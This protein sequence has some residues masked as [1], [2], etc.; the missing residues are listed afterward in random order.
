MVAIVKKDKPD[1]T[2]CS[3]TL[4]SKKFI[5]TAAHCFKHLPKDAFE[6][7]LG[8]DNLDTR[9]TNWQQYQERRDIFKL[10]IHPGYERQ[11]HNDIAI[12]ELQNEVTFNDGIYPICLPE[13][14]SP[15]SRSGHSVIVAGYGS[16]GASENKKLRSAPLQ[17][18]TQKACEDK[19]DHLNGTVDLF[20]SN[21]MCAASYVRRKCITNQQL[22]V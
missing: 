4:V 6:V 11:Y 20:T 21:T 8:T 18:L 9:P 16:T 7:V 22:F 19:Y 15:F 14:A 1:T 5:I 10:H 2:H 13:N 17:V 3:A 12:I